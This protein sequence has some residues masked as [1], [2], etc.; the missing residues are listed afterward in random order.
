MM[1]S[2]C[3][4]KKKPCSFLFVIFH[5]FLYTINIPSVNTPVN[6][7]FHFG[8]EQFFENRFDNRLFIG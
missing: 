6:A 3:L 8:T 4:F 7:P 1:G 5:V 2:R